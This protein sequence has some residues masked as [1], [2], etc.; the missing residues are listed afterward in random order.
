MP[1][2]PPAA[3]RAYSLI[4]IAQALL[5][6][7]GGIPHLIEQVVRAQPAA[8]VGELRVGFDQI[9]TARRPDRKQTAGGCARIGR[10]HDNPIRRA[11]GRSD[12]PR[13][14]VKA[15]PPMLPLAACAT[16]VVMR[17]T[18]L[19]ATLIGPR[20]LALAPQPGRHRVAARLRPR[21]GWSC[22]SAACSSAHGLTSDSTDR[23]LAIK[24]RRNSSQSGTHLRQTGG[25]FVPVCRCSRRNAASG[26]R[27]IQHPQGEYAR[28]LCA[29][30]N[31]PTSRRRWRRS[32]RIEE[33]L[34]CANRRPPAVSHP[35]AKR[36]CS[37]RLSSQP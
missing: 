29:V 34:R 2:S 1:R 21:F 35:S 16:V 28:R 31:L 7:V 19:L 15:A 26:G 6:R 20:T 32:R 25:F 27:L 10:A 8:V 33:V 12:H 36:K 3:M 24:E 23:N 18:P 14:V 13:P 30:S 11:A 37:G 17:L 22:D 4:A 9:V 5:Q